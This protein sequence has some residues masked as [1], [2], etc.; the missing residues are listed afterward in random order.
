MLI[1]HEMQYSEP[2]LYSDCFIQMNE[3]MRL[4]WY[5]QKLYWNQ[6]WGQILEVVFKYNY[7]YL[8]VLISTSTNKYYTKSIIIFQYKYKY[9]PVYLST[10]TSTCTCMHN[11][12]IKD[13]PLF[14]L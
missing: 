1:Q 7:K 14:M 11:S 2:T 5:E 3:W 4:N 6:A 10:N 8:H 9:S 12:V 13:R